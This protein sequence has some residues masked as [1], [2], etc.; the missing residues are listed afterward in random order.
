M[1]NIVNN[2]LKSSLVIAIAMM[3]TY[4]SVQAQGNP[5]GPSTSGSGILADGSASPGPSVP[6][7][8]GMSLILAASGIGYATKRL[9][10]NN[11]NQL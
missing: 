8:G 7:D 3:T 9:K 11:C 10:K 5:G 6:F 2:I 1:K 4:S